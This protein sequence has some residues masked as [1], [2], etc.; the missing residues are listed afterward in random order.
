MSTDIK[1]IIITALVLAVSTVSQARDYVP[2]PT[3]PYQ[4]SV[5]I[6]NSLANESTQ[7]IYKFPPP[8]ILQEDRNIPTQRFSPS[9]P[10]MTDNGQHELPAMIDTPMKP[11]R[12]NQQL[13]FESRP[14]MPEYNNY[15]PWQPPQGGQAAT[16]PGWYG[17]YQGANPNYN[18]QIWQQ[19][20]GYGYQQ[21]YPYSY[22]APNQYNGANNPFY[23]MPSPWNVMPK[24]MFF[25]DK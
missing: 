3:G 8:D 1:P 2:P 5:V 10:E 23:G 19:A 14:M 13:N 16:A 7:Q 6:N 11:A 17:N 4:S 24:N 12:P 25:S 22:G 15:S 21:Q 18:Q 20:P 9:D